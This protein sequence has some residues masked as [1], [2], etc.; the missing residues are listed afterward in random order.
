VEGLAVYLAGGHYKQEPLFPRAAALD[1]MG[2]Y[3]P[4]ATLADSFYTSQHEIGYLEGAALVKFLVDTFGWQA[5]NNFYRDIHPQP[6]G[7]ESEAIDVALGKHFGRSLGQ[8]ERDFRTAL[9]RQQINPD[10]ADDLRLTIEYY[11]TVRRYQQLLDPSAYFLTAWLPDGEQMRQRGIVADF[12]RHP[13]K[14]E[15]IQ[16]ETLLV[17]ADGDL[18]AGD[19]S[20]SEK[21]LIT[22]NRLLDRFEISELE[23]V[24]A[25]AVQ[26]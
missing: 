10:M 8:L 22:V 16:I 18:R 15:N 19:Y 3:L 7:K 23:L 17:Q 9:H 11:D 25:S 4:L 12:L 13:Q 2:R 6:D 1:Q 21:T 14:P 24:V 5:F 20:R 26:P